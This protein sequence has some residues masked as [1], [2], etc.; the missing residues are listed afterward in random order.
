M[1]ALWKSARP[2]RARRKPARPVRA[3][4]KPARPRRR[5]PRR[6][7]A[8]AEFAV[9]APLLFLLIFGMFE[10]GRLVM[11]QQVLTNAS[12][13]GARRGILERATAAEVET[14]VQDYL[15]GSSVSGATV[16]V[17]PGSLAGVGFGDPV[18]VTVSVPFDEVSWVPAPW[19]LGGKTMSAQSVMRAERPE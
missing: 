4:R 11:V 10:F 12:R 5:A 18:T 17:S 7:A 14:V 13:E 6:G 16:T 15:A 2:V 19:F 8:V 1:Q 3:R 9:V